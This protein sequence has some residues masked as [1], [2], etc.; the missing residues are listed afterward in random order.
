MNFTATLKG[1]LKDGESITAT[2]KTYDE[3]AKAGSDYDSFTKSVTFDKDH[4]SHTLG[5]KINDDNF[6]EDVT[7]INNIFYKN[8]R[9]IA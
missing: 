3:S 2:F 4:M 9:K 7:A 5:V 6:K 1:E 8:N